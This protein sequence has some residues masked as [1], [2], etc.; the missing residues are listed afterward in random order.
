MRNVTTV[1]G[2][3]DAGWPALAP[4]DVILVNGTFEAEPQGLLRQF[5]EGGRLVGILGSRH[6]GKAMIYRMDRG[7][8]GGRA[9]FDAS[10]PVLP[11]F[12]KAPAFVF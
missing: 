12:V 7:E 10:A 8:I 3:L 5:K 9:L 6:A 4:Y 11:A 1:C 2:P